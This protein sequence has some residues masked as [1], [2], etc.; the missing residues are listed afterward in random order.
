MIWF[1]RSSGQ[2]L[3]NS[4][5]LKKICAGGRCL[6]AL[7]PVFHG[8]LLQC[9][10]ISLARLGSRIES[11][12]YY[13]CLTPDPFGLHDPFPQVMEDLLHPTGVGES[14]LRHLAVDELLQAEVLHVVHA[15][16]VA[17]P[18]AQGVIEA[19]LF[20]HGEVAVHDGQQPGLF[21][22]EPA[23]G[24][25]EQVHAVVV[26]VVA[27]NAVQAVDEKALLLDEV[28]FRLEPV[29][30][31]LHLLLEARALFD[32]DRQHA[33]IVRVDRVQHPGGL[34]GVLLPERRAAQAQDDELGEVHAGF[35]GHGRRLD[36]IPRGDALADL[37]QDRVRSRFHAAVEQGEARLADLL[38]LRGALADHGLGP[39]VTGDSLEGGEVLPE[40]PQDF[41]EIAGLHDEAV[42][43]LQK[44]GLEGVAAVAPGGRHDVTL[45]FL[46]RS[47]GKAHALVVHA[48]LALVPGASAGGA[49]QKAVALVHGSDGTHFKR[50][51]LH[52][53]LAKVKSVF[54]RSFLRGGPTG[55]WRAV[56]PI[57]A[58]WLRMQ[59]EEK[60]PQ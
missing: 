35:L 56:D 39:A 10:M 60:L 36:E 8:V 54:S 33:D 27:R 22:G 49:D 19:L 4:K 18:P 53:F 34:G 48:E 45:D 21:L 51:G 29:L 16:V 57:L 14:E 50:I 23:P 25:H 42:A 7:N 9:P 31:P 15:P 28:P 41:Q 26:D 11:I 24:L 32:P 12:P 13:R 44:T 58:I 17:Q 37:F 47:H 5:I 6:A 38:H 59:M 52:V 43:V 2:D 1:V 30:P 3:G 20:G 46:H 40:E 55:R